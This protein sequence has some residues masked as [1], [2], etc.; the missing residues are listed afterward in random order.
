MWRTLEA[1]LRLTGSSATLRRMELSYSQ[2]YTTMVRSCPADQ[3][4][5]RVSEGVS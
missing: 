2:T 5:A 3:G 4:P 1:L